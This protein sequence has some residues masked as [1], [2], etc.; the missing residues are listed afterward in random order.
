MFTLKQVQYLRRIKL[1]DKDCRSA[2]DDLGQ[3]VNKKSAGMEHR[4]DIQIN[5]IMGYVMDD[6]IQCIPRDHAM[7]HLRSFGK[8]RCPTREDQ[9]RDIFRL[10]TGAGHR[11]VRSGL[12]SCLEGE[13]ARDSISFQMQ[14]RER[15]VGSE[16]SDILLK[17]I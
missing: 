14:S 3:C 4:K 1:A 8:T 7:R 10:E 13:R 17:V 15:K 12:E 11:R 9:G 5:I 16:L 2:K 6:C